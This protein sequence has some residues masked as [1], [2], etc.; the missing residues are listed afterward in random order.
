MNAFDRIKISQMPQVSSSLS[1]AYSPLIVPSGS[2]Y[3]NRKVSIGDLGAYITGSMITM[4]YAVTSSHS[5]TALTASMAISASYEINYETSSSYAETA[6]IAVSSSH[7]VTSSYSISSSQSATASYALSDSK[8]KIEVYCPT[9]PT[10]GTKA[11]FDVEVS[12]DLAFSTLVVS[13][14]TSTN[15]TGFYYFNGLI[16]L[17]YP[18][19]G[20][21][22]D[23]F[24]DQSVIYL[25]SYTDPNSLYYRI[26]PVV[27]SVAGD[28]SAGTL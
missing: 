1:G 19:L 26:R 5:L 9:T 12:S 4:S 24:G 6:S 7:S 28:W 10:G 14:S 25:F 11:H 27:N 3:A 22:V 16:Y 15:Q 13:Q 17:A 20:V 23:V 21:D 2:G 8:R 18:A